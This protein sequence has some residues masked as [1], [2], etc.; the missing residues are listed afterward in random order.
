MAAAEFPLAPDAAEGP[1]TR[2][3]TVVVVGREGEVTLALPGAGRGGD[4][5]DGGSAVLARATDPFT[6]VLAAAFSVLPAG[7][8]LRLTECLRGMPLTPF[9]WL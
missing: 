8:E 2:E 7:T 4:G 6:G 3:P 5:C 1:L 9:V